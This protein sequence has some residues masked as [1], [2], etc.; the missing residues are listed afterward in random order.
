MPSR[1]RLD[2]AR[3]GAVLFE[4]PLQALILEAD[5][6]PRWI[7]SMFTN[8]YSDVEP[9]QGRRSVIADDR[10]RVGGL[11]DWYRLDERRYLGL[12]E[13]LSVEAFEARFRMFLVLED[14]ELV[15]VEEHA[16]WSLQGA[17]CG[18]VLAAA[19]LPFPEADH[20]HV[21]VEGLRVLRKDRGAGG[22]DLLLPAARVEELGARLRAAGA[23]PAGPEVALGLRILAGRASWPEDG[24]DKSMVHE[25]ELQR[26][27]VSFDKGCYLGQEVIN[28]IERVG[29]VRK[30]LRR[31]LVEGPARAGD[32][33]LLGEEEVGALSSVLVLDEGVSLALGVLREAA[34]A[35]E[36]ALRVGA[37]GSSLPARALP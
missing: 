27:C 17:R 32:P 12:L 31:L 13:G 22:V 1:A 18:E 15:P 2:A 29:G 11:V 5:G 10:G 6:L 33:V 16:L 26:E 20:A 25:L 37:E 14:I 4:L 35:P 30:K 7:N 9:G 34:W 8:K 19:G 24:N 28:R 36:A 23:E 3:Q 21:E